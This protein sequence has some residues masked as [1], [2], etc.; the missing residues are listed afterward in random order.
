MK[1]TTWPVGAAFSWVLKNWRLPGIFIAIVKGH[2]ELV[3]GCLFMASP[4]VASVSDKYLVSANA[5]FI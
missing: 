3:G 5:V 4:S 1:K 2:L